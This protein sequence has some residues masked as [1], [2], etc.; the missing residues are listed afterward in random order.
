MYYFLLIE[1]SFKMGS[2]DDANWPINM[3]ADAMNTLIVCCLT[4]C[5][6]N[7]CLNN[8]SCIGKELALGHGTDLVYI[9]TEKIG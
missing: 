5:D 8:K 9:A 3:A 2:D 4:S 1:T 7:K 6:E